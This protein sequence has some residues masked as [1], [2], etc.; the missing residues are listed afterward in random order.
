MPEVR[1]LPRRL[2][3]RSEVVETP[4]CGPG[5]SRFESGR[6]PQRCGRSGISEVSYASRGGFDSRSRDQRARPDRCEVVELVPR[7]ALNQEARVR[8]VASQPSMPLQS[9]RSLTFE[10]ACCA[11]G[12]SQ[13]DLITP[14]RLR[15]TGFLPL[16]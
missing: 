5:G 9:S 12:G 1:L 14:G 11:D 10:S 3:P 16:A 2:W 6:S 7:L 8:T 15:R 13:A 4:G